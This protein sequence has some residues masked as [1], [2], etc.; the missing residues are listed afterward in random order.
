MIILVDLKKLELKAVRIQFKL[1]HIQNTSFF[2]LLQKQ[3][4]LI[5][6]GL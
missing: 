1:G 2:N 3:I 6:D 4:L 5:V